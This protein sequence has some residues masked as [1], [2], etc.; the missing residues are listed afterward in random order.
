MHET[1]LSWLIPVICPIIAETMSRS[2]ALILKAAT[3]TPG[4]NRVAQQLV[5]VSDTP[6]VAELKL[7]DQHCNVLET[8][9]GGFSPLL[10]ELMSSAHLQL[11]G[12]PPSESVDLNTM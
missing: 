7:E 5:A 12:H 3:T 4:F 2:L 6:C 11:K 1:F 10:V 9:H 8:L